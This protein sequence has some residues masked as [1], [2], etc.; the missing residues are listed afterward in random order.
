LLGCAALLAVAELS[1]W[2]L[3][4]LVPMAIGTRVVNAP[5]A[6]SAICGAYLLPRTL[7]SLVQP[8]LPLP[9]LLLIPSMA[10]DVTLW[11]RAADFRLVR[12]PWR[13]RPKVHRTPTRLRGALAGA[14]FGVTLAAVEGSTQLDALMTI[15]ISALIGS[16]SARG[17]AS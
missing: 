3:L 6:A 10:F 16:F 5:G 1:E 12:P 2:R 9:P 7:L 15:A 8:G 4:M 17:T 11:L 14:V 13:K